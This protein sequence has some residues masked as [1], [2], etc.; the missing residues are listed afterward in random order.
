MTETCFEFITILSTKYRYIKS[1]LVAFGSPTGSIFISDF[2]RRMAQCGVRGRAV[3][4]ANSATRRG[5]QYATAPTQAQL[6]PPV[7]Y[8]VMRTFS[9][10]GFEQFMMECEDGFEVNNFYI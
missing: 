2:C 7:L 4:L 10:S 8:C 1:R 9:N 5:R 3:R 6:F